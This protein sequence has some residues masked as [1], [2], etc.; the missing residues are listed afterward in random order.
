MRKLNSIEAIEEEIK[1][2]A[3]LLYISAPN[4]NVCDALKVKVQALFSRDFPKIELLEANV[5]EVPQITGRFNIFSAPAMLIFFDGQEFV[6]EG[7]N[8]SLELLR[9]KLQKIY[10]VYFGL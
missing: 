1:E 4:C 2:G 3:K 7:R 8:V 6:R 5:A 10:E 9:G